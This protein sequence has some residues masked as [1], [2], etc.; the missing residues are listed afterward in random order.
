MLA[1]EKGHESQCWDSV[2]FPFPF[3]APFEMKRILRLNDDNLSEY[4]I[5]ILWTSCLRYTKR[6]RKRKKSFTDLSVIFYFNDTEGLYVSTVYESV[7]FSCPVTSSCDLVGNAHKT[8]MKVLWQTRRRGVNKVQF[9]AVCQ[10]R[11]S[12]SPYALHPVFLKF[13]KHC[14]CF[15]SSVDLVD[16]DPFSSLQG[17]LPSTAYSALSPSV[18]TVVKLVDWCFEPSQPL[19][20][21]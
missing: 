2:S 17:R 20:I 10:L 6:N 12:E 8:G 9:S 7:S 18:C 13:S 4:G 15:S 3:H 5:R 21:I 19:G 11:S 16:D 14:L 1:E